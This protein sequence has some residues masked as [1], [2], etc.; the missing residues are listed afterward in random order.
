MKQ[1]DINDNRSEQR[2]RE[3]NV[4]IEQKENST[5]QL[6]REYRDKEMGNEERAQKLAG[7]TGWNRHGKEMKKSVESKDQEDEA[8]KETGDDKSSF[9]VSVFCLI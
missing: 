6:D 3:W 1:Q 9:H 4:A 8:E 7:N 5:D 2:Q